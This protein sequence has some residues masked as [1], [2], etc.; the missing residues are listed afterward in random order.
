M[1][2]RASN[3]ISRT[4]SMFIVCVNLV[5]TRSLGWLSLVGNARTTPVPDR[6]LAIAGKKWALPREAMSAFPLNSAIKANVCTQLSLCSLNITVKVFEIE[7]V[8]KT[9]LR[10]IRPSTTKSKHH[11]PFQIDVRED[12]A[13]DLTR[14]SQQIYPSDFNFHLHLSLFQAC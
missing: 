6:C 11:P 9:L 7:A 5:L 12:H 8:I 3:V 14:I 13:A 10:S 1:V 4:R 2:W